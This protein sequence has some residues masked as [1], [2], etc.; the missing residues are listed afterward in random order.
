MLI[1]LLQ[2]KLCKNLRKLVKTYRMTVKKQDIYLQECIL[3][4][5]KESM[6]FSLSSIPCN[7]LLTSSHRTEIYLKKCLRLEQRRDNQEMLKLF[8]LKYNRVLVHFYRAR[9]LS[10]GLLLGNNL[11]KCHELEKTYKIKFRQI[12]MLPH[13]QLLISEEEMVQYKKF[14][15]FNH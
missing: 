8:K 7:I 9:N 10:N 12:I 11:V 14:Q 3:R 1:L 13:I 2:L 15:G 6:V 5:L 4:L